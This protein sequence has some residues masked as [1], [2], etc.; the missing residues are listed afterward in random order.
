MERKTVLSR[1]AWTALKRHDKETTFEA[2]EHN[3]W[4][5]MRIKITIILYVAWQRKTKALNSK[6]W[7]ERRLDIKMRCFR[8]S[9]TSAF[10]KMERHVIIF[11]CRTQ[12]T[13]RLL[14]PKRDKKNTVC[15]FIKMTC[16]KKIRPRRYRITVTKFSN[17]NRLILLLAMSENTTLLVVKLCQCRPMAYR[18][19]LHAPE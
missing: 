4:L 7:D 3:Q 9:S 18:G 19:D 6:H 1:T 10:N 2:K 13:R 16:P 12:Q 5:S 11:I 14:L 15:H 8:K 17:K